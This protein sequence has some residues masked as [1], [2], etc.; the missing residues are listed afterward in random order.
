M[1][2]SGAGFG[3]GGNGTA[4]VAAAGCNNDW[5]VWYIGSRT[6]WNVTKSF[7]LGVDV[8]YEELNSATTGSAGAPLGYSG[9]TSAATSIGGATGTEAHSS[10]WTI[11]FRAHRDFLP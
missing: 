1:L 11:R 7:Y 9:G 3:T 6:Q 2:C 5:S 4:A 8:M 10:N